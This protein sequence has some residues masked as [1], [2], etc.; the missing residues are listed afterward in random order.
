[1]SREEENEREGKNWRNRSIH[2]G[3][4]RAIRIGHSEALKKVGMLEKNK[5]GAR[6]PF[7]LA[8]RRVLIE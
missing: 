5:K 2:G 3:T 8:V 7:K 6:Q 1:M 4:E